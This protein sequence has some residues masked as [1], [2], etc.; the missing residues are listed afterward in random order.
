MTG[1]DSNNIDTM[2]YQL[3]KRGTV[4]D[5]CTILIIHYSSALYISGRVPFSMFSVPWFLCRKVAYSSRNVGLKYLVWLL[6]KVNVLSQP[7]R[8]I[9]KIIYGQAV[10][11]HLR[12]NTPID[13]IS[14]WRNPNPNPNPSINVGRAGLVSIL[15]LTSIGDLCRQPFHLLKLCWLCFKYSRHNFIRI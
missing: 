13:C 10:F 9:Q 4:M 2:K 1:D 3:S 14:N 5:S 12:T 6:G 7:K 8:I 15:L 11:H